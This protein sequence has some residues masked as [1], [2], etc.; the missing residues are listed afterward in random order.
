MG[1]NLANVRNKG[2][3]IVLDKPRKLKFD[4]NAFAELEETFGDVE[5]AMAELEKGKIKALRAI[6]WAGLVHEDAALTVTDVGSM[7]DMSNLEV[8]MEAINR[9][10]SGALPAIEEDGKNA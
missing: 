3:D 10:I 9:G 1:Q 2:I 6:L 4:L 8:V 7:I 5:T